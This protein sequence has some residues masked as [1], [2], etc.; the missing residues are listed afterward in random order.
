MR[1][2]HNNW[3]IFIIFIANNGF[4]FNNVATKDTPNPL[5]END[6]GYGIVKNV[7]SSDTGH[8]KRETLESF[9]ISKIELPA[10]DKT[11]EKQHNFVDNNNLNKA[12][13]AFR[14]DETTQTKNLDIKESLTQQPNLSQGISEPDQ[15]VVLTLIDTASTEL[16]SIAEPH[17]SSN[18]GQASTNN[19]SQSIVSSDFES[20]VEDPEKLKISTGSPVNLIVDDNIIN[21]DESLSTEQSTEFQNDEIQ[22]QFLQDHKN[23]P[24][25]SEK[26]RKTTEELSASGELEESTTQTTLLPRSSEES[27]TASL[28]S[29]VGSDDSENHEDIPSYNEWTQKKMEED[30]K[31][32]THPNISI[33]NLGT[34]NR[35]V[36]S[37]KVRSKNYASLDCG[38]KVAGSNSGAQGAR[39]VLVSTRDEYMLNP[40]T[41]KVWFVVELCEAIQAKKIE[42][43]NFELF[44]SS[45]KNFS[46][47]ISKNPTKDWSPV[48]QFI[49]KDERDIQSFYLQP[50]LF[51]KFIKVELHSHYGS[52]HFCPISLFRAYGI[53][54]FEVLETETETKDIYYDDEK[55]DDDEDEEDSEDD[56]MI[57]SDDGEIYNVINNNN[58][59]ENIINNHDGNESKNL[60]GSARDAVI[61]IV[62]KAA[63]VLVK[64]ENFSVN[65][66]NT[67]TQTDIV[68][69]IDDTF[70]D[71]ITPR[72][73]ILC[74]NCTENYFDKVFELISCRFKYLDSILKI[75]LI[76]QAISETEVCGFNGVN[77]NFNRDDS[78]VKKK[79]KN[80]NVSK[81]RSTSLL[82]S[83]F[84]PEYIVAL[85]NIFAINEQKLPLN[86]TFVISNNLSINTVT[87][88]IASL[89]SESLTSVHKISNLCTLDS[90]NCKS[91]I[92]HSKEPQCHSQGPFIKDDIFTTDI[93]NSKVVNPSGTIAVNEKEILLITPTKTL[94]D[95]NTEK[96]SPVI[97]LEP[98]KS[99]A[100]ET[101]QS[102]TIISTPLTNSD[103]GTSKVF[104]ELSLTDT[105]IESASQ[106]LSSSVVKN[107]ENNYKS[108][109]ANNDKENIIINSK[110]ITKISEEKDDK[111]KERDQDDIKLTPQEQLSLDTLLLDLKALENDPSIQGSTASTVIQP[112]A[113]STP[114]QKESVFLRLSNRIKTLER[115][116]SLSAQYLEELSRRYK[117]QVEEMQRSLERATTTIGEELKK[118]EEKELK[119]LEEITLL[120]EEILSLTE[121]VETLLYDKS[122]WKNKL[123]IFGQHIVLI[124]VEITI[125]I[126]IIILCRKPSDIKDV[127]IKKNDLNKGITRRKSA[128][129]ITTGSTNKKCRRPSEIVSRIKGSYRDLMIDE[130]L[131]TR[132]ERKKKRRRDSAIRSS[133]NIEINKNAIPKTVL[134]KQ[135]LSINCSNFE[136]SDDHQ[137]KTVDMSSDT[138]GTP[139]KNQLSINNSDSSVSNIL[140]NRIV[141]D[142]IDSTSLGKIVNNSVGSQDSPGIYS[143]FEH[144]NTK[145]SSRGLR[146][147]KTAKFHSPYFM[148]TA[149]QSRSK[150]DKLEHHHNLQSVQ[151]ISDN[152]EKYSRTSGSS[153]SG[154]DSPSSLSAFSDLLSVNLNNYNVNGDSAKNNGSNITSSSVNGHITPTSDVKIKKEGSLR[155][156]VKKL[157]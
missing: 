15:D 77:F 80:F 133:S 81:S 94:I 56:D 104:E 53:S 141:V 43:A 62:K 90:T 136:N 59:N 17:L 134:P 32:K 114:Q 55:L 145:N 52:E 123:L 1:L 69:D 35:S 109:T 7:S 47:F 93:K 103:V 34:P 29:F 66:N 75:T 33:Q 76:N 135:S 48:G 152:W 26:I 23:L 122:S 100:E 86:S 83:I 142:E 49:A 65:N 96:K 131:D 127:T 92:T 121:S 139:L 128:E 61:S 16:H 4:L 46:V 63:E 5:I 22:S 126:I 36:G 156:I 147:L 40:C 37:M 88:E 39:N 25:D 50:Q 117:K 18:H 113:S 31:K 146:I 21:F 57:N 118:N 143:D 64:T 67:K 74:N 82:I 44:S 13:D 10:H 60:F 154:Q 89:S 106:T 137:I 19:F 153:R 38:A 132:K 105:S 70:I 140:K 78:I 115:N 119:R 71:C 85:C 28:D 9:L 157:F 98:S 101:V 45:P 72:Y 14:N 12:D 151:L 144:E 20:S 110:S 120:R 138:D 30:E 68:N 125:L 54:E 130:R 42:L 51:G 2:H 27:G 11:D 107:H 112:V 24:N 91:I 102:E 84:K 87:P 129:L 58:N 149:F 108:I 79:T 99:L 95:D 111:S 73:T 124:F 97:I 116:M 3:I 150:K 148:K 8:S 155:K 6:H 41:S